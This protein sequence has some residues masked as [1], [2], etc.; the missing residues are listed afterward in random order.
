MTQKRVLPVLF[1]SD[2][3]EQEREHIW[4]PPYQEGVLNHKDPN[5][6]RENSIYE[7]QKAHLKEMKRH[8]ISK[9]SRKS[10]KVTRTRLSFLHRL[11]IAAIVGLSFGLILSLIIIGSREE[12]LVGNLL[13][14][15]EREKCGL[16]TDEQCVPR[17][18]IPQISPVIL[19]MTRNLTTSQ[20]LLDC[21]YNVSWPTNVTFREV[22][23]RLI[24]YKE[25]KDDNLDSLAE[26]VL[27][28]IRRNPQWG[29]SLVNGSGNVTNV[30]NHKTIDSILIVP[31]V[32]ARSIFCRVTM[33]VTFLWN[34]TKWIMIGGVL[35]LVGCLLVQWYVRKREQEIQSMF[36]MVDRI[37]E[38]LRRHYEEAK[39]DDNVLPYLAI[40]HV[41]DM[42]IPPPER[43]HKQRTWDKAVDWLASYESRVRVETRKIAGEEF[44]VWRWIQIG[45]PSTDNPA[46]LIRG[47]NWQGSA[48]D[49]YPP[50]LSAKI[51]PPTGQPSK[52]IRLKNM[53]EGVRKLNAEQVQ[54]IE[55][56]VLDRCITHGG[57]VHIK[58]DRRSPYGC[59]YFKMD[60][61]QSAAKTYKALHGGWF[62]G[63]LI[64]AKYIPESKYHKWFPDAMVAKKFLYPPD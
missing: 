33:F 49:D 35:L 20:G 27:L 51:A 24:R 15:E 1:S 64:T 61:L 58:V 18:H 45:P 38:V 59:V 47:K 41:R 56:S 11:I 5:S 2:E 28:L 57:V 48:I 44:T 40:V 31:N 14:C 50:A 54:D 23:S 9:S 4:S 21:E 22:K 29:L 36:I 10:S 13:D 52:C 34:W 19:D 55:S 25:D 3:E 63:K 17:S 16:G 46:Y 7:R 39:K 30:W 32:S 8:S 42:L 12:S 53:F 60:S 26:S 43:K 6:L 37:L 62:K